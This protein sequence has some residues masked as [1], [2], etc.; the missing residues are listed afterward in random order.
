MSKISIEL[1]GSDAEL[2]SFKHSG[3]RSLIFDFSVMLD[4]YISLGALTSRICG[5]ECAI[6]TVRLDDGEY[7]PHLILADR[8][9]DLPKIKKQYGIITPL[10]PDISFVTKLS[11]RERR[12]EKRV[13][14]MEKRLEELTKKVS[15]TRLFGGTP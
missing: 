8:T 9:V 14:D 6:D 11:L 2:I 1:I 15:G 5:T 7:T 13:D 4:G 12:L 10:E 3:E